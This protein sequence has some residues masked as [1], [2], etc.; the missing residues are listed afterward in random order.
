MKLF[1]I[2]F[3]LCLNCDDSDVHVSVLSWTVSLVSG[4]VLLRFKWQQSRGEADSPYR[5]LKPVKAIYY[6]TTIEIM[7]SS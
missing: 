3:L 7:I 4:L 6:I 2:L 1:I 5:P